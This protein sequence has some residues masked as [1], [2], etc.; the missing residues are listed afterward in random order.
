MQPDLMQ[1]ADSITKSHC[2]VIIVIFIVQIQTSMQEQVF[3]CKA[4]G[5]FHFS[6]HT[7]IFSSLPPLKNT[8]A[9]NP[10]YTVML[11]TVSRRRREAVTQTVQK[12]VAELTLSIWEGQPSFLSVSLQTASA[13][14]SPER[15][16]I[17]TN[18]RQQAFQ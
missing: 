3:V 8:H 18:R 6:I 7:S 17:N 10:P 11:P 5:C 15:Q 16:P 9:H 14:L 12:T 1:Q 13:T 2:F 4:K